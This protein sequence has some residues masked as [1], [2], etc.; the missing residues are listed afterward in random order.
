MCCSCCCCLNFIF[1]ALRLLK[2]LKL[3]WGWQAFFIR[4]FEWLHSLFFRLH[5][6][7][8]I[9]P[10]KVNICSFFRSSLSFKVNLTSTF[11]AIQILYTVF[12]RQFCSCAVTV[13]RYCRATEFA[14]FLCILFFALELHNSCYSNCTV[15]SGDYYFASEALLLFAS[16]FQVPHSRVSS[17]K[18]HCV[19]TSIDSS[20]E[21][22]YLRF[23]GIVC[24]LISKLSSVRLCWL[25]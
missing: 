3:L 23:D 24:P 17:W 15:L 8:N 20:I 7:W 22:N 16:F 1:I 19:T 4:S 13:P 18:Q 10:K 21:S 14:E 9:L 25:L 5:S 11:V 6:L 2:L 12:R